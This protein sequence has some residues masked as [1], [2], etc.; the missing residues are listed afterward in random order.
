ML[1]NLLERH[2]KNGFIMQERYEI[3]DYIGKGSYGIV[4]RAFDRITK[5]MVVVKQQ[6]KRKDRIS[7]NS[8]KKE[9]HFLTSL[10]H[11]S[12]PKCFDLINDENKYFL[13]MEYIDGK[14]FEELI[15][16]EGK[17]LDEAESLHILLEILAVIKYLHNNRVIHRDLRLPNIIIMKGHIYIIDFGLALSLNEKNLDESSIKLSFEKKLY[18]E[19]SVKSDFYAMGHFLLFLLYSGYNLTSEKE[20]SWEE[21]LT[22]S[23]KTRFIIR[24]LL[25]IDRSYE[26]IEEVINDVQ[27]SLSNLANP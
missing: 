6:R 5:Q 17:K 26:S 14:N 25:K 4:Y 18:R 11:P 27:D 8:F 20:K 22:I 23:G 2:L 21:E 10:D 13:I 15:L 24:R 1:N 12:I 19:A 7:N 3:I 16:E 9:F